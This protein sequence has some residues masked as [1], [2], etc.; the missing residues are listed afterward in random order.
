MI[1]NWLPNGMR[2]EWW[3]E[4]QMKGM[5]IWWIG[6][7]TWMTEWWW[8]EMSFWFKGFALIQKYLSFHPHSVI[9]SSFLSDETDGNEVKMNRMTIEWNLCIVVF[10]PWHSNIFS[11]DE[12]MTEWGQSHPI[13]HWN[14]QIYLLYKY[15]PMAHYLRLAFIKLIVLCQKWDNTSTVT[16]L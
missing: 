16:G 10:I 5:I 4:R 9:S 7:L 6:Y 8:N 14:V 15:I 2:W 1:W 11:N 13:I 3:N 12:G